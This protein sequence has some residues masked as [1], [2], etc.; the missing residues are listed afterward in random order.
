MAADL[1]GFHGA[2]YDVERTEF[3]PLISMGR[4]NAVEFFSLLD[5]VKPNMLFAAPRNILNVVEKLCKAFGIA[6]LSE[7][8][9]DEGAGGPLLK[10]DYMWIAIGRD[11]KELKELLNS[12]PRKEFKKIGEL[13]GY[14][15][16][17]INSLMKNVTGLDDKE[18]YI[19]EAKGRS[20]RFCF[21]TNNVFNFSSRLK[22][23]DMDN[24]RAFFVRNEKADIIHRVHHLINLHLISHIPCS[25][26][27]S[28]S[29]QIGNRT[30][31]AVRRFDEGM[32]SAIKETLKKPV[33]FFGDFRFIVFDGKAGGN[34]IEYS[35][36][37]PPYSLI[38][39]DIL[40]KICSGDGLMVGEK[41]IEILRDG[42]TLHTLDISKEK[43]CFVLP[44]A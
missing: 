36:I 34:R 42:K 7:H 29:V 28:R 4:L 21:Q 37:S 31:K 33:L 18:L 26:D 19:Q 24:L 27:C 22:Q 38:E 23:K 20:L 1:T 32:A 6:C 41:G 43:Y 17:C 14:P 25:Y 15:D 40:K 13:L 35:S 39:D 44:F 3:E 2:V 11:R 8:A 10:S 5:G 30:L 9:T 16:C 12:R